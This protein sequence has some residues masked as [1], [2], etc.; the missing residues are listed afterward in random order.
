MNGTTLD[1]NQ[2]GLILD[3]SYVSLWV[4]AMLTSLVS[5]ISAVGVMLHLWRSQRHQPFFRWSM[6]D[7]FTFYLG[8]YE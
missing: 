6:G 7:R 5:F 4:S 1:G 3:R 8:N 2:I